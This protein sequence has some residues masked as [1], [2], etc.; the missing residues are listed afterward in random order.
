MLLDQGSTHITLLM[1]PVHGHVDVCVPLCAPTVHN[2]CSRRLCMV[3]L[4][5]VFASLA[6]VDQGT[7]IALEFAVVCPP[8]GPLLRLCVLAAAGPRQ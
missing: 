5:C 1:T 2:T 4:T 3:T 7:F 8:V 6:N